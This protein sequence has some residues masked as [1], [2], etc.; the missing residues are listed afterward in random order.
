MCTAPA[1]PGRSRETAPFIVAH[2]AGNDLDLLRRAED[3]RIPLI[4]ADV[5]LFAGRLEVRHLK[6]LGPVPILWDRWRVAAPWTPRLTLPALLAEARPD[7]E[8]MLD[9][10]GRDPSLTP[11]VRDALAKARTRQVSVCSQNWDL[12]EALR[13]LPGVRCVHSVGGRRGLSA[14]L[15]RF[16]GQRLGGV[17]IHRKLLDSSVV[18]ELRRRAEMVLSWPVET[19]AEGRQLAGWGVDGLIT[20]K[21]E[22]LGPL[23]HVD[24]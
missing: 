21:F 20:S 3:L 17:S 8:L 18:A 6:T 19:P 12:L 1:T 13:D 22:T 2:R 15:T 24:G 23:W 14:L 10:K 5:R 4:E 7:T 9:L 11:M 16:G